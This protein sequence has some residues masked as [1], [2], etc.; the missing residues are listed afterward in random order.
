MYKIKILIARIS[1]SQIKQ[2]NGGPKVINKLSTQ[3]LKLSKK[4]YTDNF[5]RKKGT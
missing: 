3:T 4:K 2:R 5:H 1:T